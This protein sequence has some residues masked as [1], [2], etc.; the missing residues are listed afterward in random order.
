L[1]KLTRLAEIYNVAIVYTNQV[2][3]QPDNFFGGSGGSGFGS[4]IAAGGNI[5]AHA[6]TY[7]IFL[8]KAGHNRIATM[9]NSPYHAYSQVKFT[10]DEQGIRDLEKKD[11]S[12]AGGNESG[13]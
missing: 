10:I 3:A 6:S 13:W 2:Q 7:R 5:M 4:M 1:H 9:L 8:R 12:A 11:S